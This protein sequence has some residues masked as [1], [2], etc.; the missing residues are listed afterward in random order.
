MFIEYCLNIG[1]IT[2]LSG[3]T[4]MDSRRSSPSKYRE[5]QSS[6]RFGLNQYD[7][8]NN[9]EPLWISLK[10]TMNFSAISRDGSAQNFLESQLISV[11]FQEDLYPDTQADIPA[12]TAAEW[13]V[14]F[15]FG[16]IANCLREFWGR[17]KNTLMIFDTGGTV[18]MR[19][20]WWCRWQMVEAA[21]LD[22][23]F[24]WVYLLEKLYSFIFLSCF[25]YSVTFGN[26]IMRRQ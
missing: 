12:I 14:F 17:K 7:F 26:I 23:R 24:I 18:R 4:T 6:S 22:N 19:S 15:Y 11:K 3:W 13:S 1:L 16:D 8:G 5:S 9:L 20:L 2:P 21:L 25:F 10:N